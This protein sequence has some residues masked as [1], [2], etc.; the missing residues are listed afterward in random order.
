MIEKEILNSLVFKLIKHKETHL[1]EAQAILIDCD[2]EWHDEY[3]SV[4]GYTPPFEED[5]IEHLLDFKI[6]I[7]ACNAYIDILEEITNLIKQYKI[8]QNT[9]VIYNEEVDGNFIP[10]S[11]KKELI[12]E[13]KETLKECGEFSIL[14]EI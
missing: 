10:N 5:Q 7:S 3:I 4:Y 8:N 6:E 13:I 12:K 9:V 2:L 1:E 11:R 14:W